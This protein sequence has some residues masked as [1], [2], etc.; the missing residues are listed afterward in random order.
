MIR[1]NFRGVRDCLSVDVSCRPLPRRGGSGADTA[2][3]GKAEGPGQDREG[4]YYPA[5]PDEPYRRVQGL[6]G[7]CAVQL[8]SAR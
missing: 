7:E 2:G 4:A 3:G 6:R 5:R 1:A 8:P